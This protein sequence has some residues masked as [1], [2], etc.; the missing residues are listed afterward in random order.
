MSRL[1]VSWYTEPTHGSQRNILLDLFKR[2]L[3]NQGL[4]N[5]T[6][7]LYAGRVKAFLDYAA[8]GRVHHLLNRDSEGHHLFNS[9]DMICKSFCYGWSSLQPLSFAQGDI[10]L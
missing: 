7:I 2:Y 4:H 10:Q 8:I 6:I 9:P 5:K 3:R 1:N